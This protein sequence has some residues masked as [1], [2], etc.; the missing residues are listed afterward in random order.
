M[1]SRGEGTSGKDENRR[2]MYEEDSSIM[3]FP[4]GPFYHSLS[5]TVPH[6]RQPELQVVP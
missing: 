3:G 1:V 5:P 2:D 6:P 4:K